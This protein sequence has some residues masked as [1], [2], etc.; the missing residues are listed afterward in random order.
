[1]QF[2]PA[3]LQHAPSSAVQ[4]LGVQL[5]WPSVKIERQ[6]AAARMKQAPVPVQQEP[7]LGQGLGLQTDPGP[8]K[9]FGDT[10]PAAVMVVHAP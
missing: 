9:M 4:G 6:P 7:T 3:L 1:L 5:V 2:P 10:Q 8:W